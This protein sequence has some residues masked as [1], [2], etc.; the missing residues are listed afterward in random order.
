MKEGG[1]DAVDFSSNSQRSKGVVLAGKA[2]A[3]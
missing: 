1:A 3:L 2:F